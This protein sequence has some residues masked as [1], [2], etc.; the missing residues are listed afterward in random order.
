MTITD[1]AALGRRLQ[2]VRGLHW[3]YGCNGDPYSTL[4][5]GQDDDPLRL[6]RALREP[7]IWRSRTETWVVTDHASALLVL[8]DPAFTR[9]T[10]RTPEWMRAAGAP[11]SSWAQPFRE[12]H[13]TS[14]EGEVP[15][16]SELVERLTG[17]LPRA[18]TR[19]DLVRDFAWQVPA[20][21]ILMDDPKAL[22]RAWDTRF[23]L[24]AQISPQSLV[25]VETAIAALPADPRWRALFSAAE[26]T[27]NTL[28]N[29]VL[30]V[31]GTPGLAER[32]A[33]D[34]AIAPR[35]VSEVLRL[36]PTLHLERRTAVAESRLGENNIAVGDEVVVLVAGANRDPHVFTD[37]DRF[38]VDRGDAGYAL[39]AQRGHPG[40]LEALVTALAT[41]ALTSVATALPRLALNGQVVRR[42]RS[43]VLRA[44]AHCPVEI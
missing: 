39:S 24:D 13:A 40:T 1:R 9:A 11:P 17:V 35:L 41:A 20:R 23:S 29:S 18:G 27:A 42:R 33:D 44:T 28:V 4:L 22:R 32:F 15:D 34:Q 2:M 6:Y 7:G 12:V 3:G 25:A 30:A 10:G 43:P 38:D 36:H 37:P 14:W 26:L 8:E 5:C 31:K 21:G 16:T 19:L